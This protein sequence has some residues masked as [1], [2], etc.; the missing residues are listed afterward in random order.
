MLKSTSAGNM[1]ALS[2]LMKGN[3]FVFT[4]LFSLLR[5]LPL[6][7]HYNHQPSTKTFKETPLWN[8][9]V[10]V[11]RKYDCAELSHERSNKLFIHS[12]RVMCFFA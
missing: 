6:T 3:I 7:V 10:H 1:T 9:G 12:Y 8:V 4:F 5:N 2:C 11:S